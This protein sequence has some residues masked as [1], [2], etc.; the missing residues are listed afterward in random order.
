MSEGHTLVVPKRHVTR[1]EQLERAEWA[2]LF[3]LVREVSR[4]LASLPGVEGVNVGVNSG[5]AA[6]QTVGHAHVHVIPRRPGDVEDPRGGIR[7]VIAEKADYWT[8]REDEDLSEPIVLGEK[9]LSLLDESSTSSTY[10]PALLLAIID[11]APEYP[12]GADPGQ[13]PGRAGDRALLAADALLPDHTPGSEPEPGQE[14]E[15]R[16]LD[17]RIPQGDRRQGP[18]AATGASKRGEPEMGASAPGRG[19]QP[20]R[21]ADP[22]APAALRTFPLRIRLALVRRGRLVGPQS[23]KPGAAGARVRRSDSCPGSLRP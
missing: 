3:D 9:L 2:G 19:A 14:G 5:E 11:R 18:G 7:W 13:L 4:E 1:A 15:D 12:D 6:G 8:A 16:H 23:T 10:K 21:D 22:K 20:C 17:P